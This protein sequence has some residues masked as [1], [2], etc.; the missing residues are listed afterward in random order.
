MKAPEGLNPGPE[1]LL[2]SRGEGHQE[3]TGSKRRMD[4]NN[5]SHSVE[6]MTKRPR[7]HESGTYTE[8]ADPLTRVIVAESYPEEVLGAKHLALLRGAVSKEIDGIL[9]DPMPRFCST[10]LRAGAAVVTCADE[11][12]LRWLT[13]QIGNISP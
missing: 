10:Y 3:I 5:I 7:A 13:K 6:R 9:E 2:V 12:S 8:T 11:A 4:S 1:V